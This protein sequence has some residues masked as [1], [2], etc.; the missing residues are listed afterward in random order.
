MTHT[1][2]R[3]NI[4]RPAGKVRGAGVAEKCACSQ[5]SGRPHRNH[6]LTSPARS[7][8]APTAVASIASSRR[9]TCTRRSAGFRPRCVATTRSGA[10][11]QSRRTSSAER[12]SCPSTERSTAAALV[13]RCRGGQSPVLHRKHGHRHRRARAGARGCVRTGGGSRCPL[14]AIRERCFRVQSRGGA[15]I[16]E[17]VE[18]ARAELHFLQRD[19]LRVQLLQYRR[20]A[21]RCELAVAPDA[22][23]DVVRSDGDAQLRHRASA[24]QQSRCPEPQGGGARTARAR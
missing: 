20:G 24:P 7:V 8:G 21:A 1:R 11:S 15:Q 22:D 4:G 19:D 3:A 2:S 5:R 12:G 6:S 16:L 10:P 23:V 13:I 9:R 18:R 17:H 14:R